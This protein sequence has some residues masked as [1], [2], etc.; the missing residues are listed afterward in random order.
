MAPVRNASG[1]GLSLDRPSYR[2]TRCRNTAVSSSVPIRFAKRQVS[3]RTS[4][5]SYSATDA[6]SIAALCSSFGPL[7][8]KVLT[9]S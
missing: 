3:E 2:L 6:V 9:A 5:T 1:G 4:A 8:R 7:P